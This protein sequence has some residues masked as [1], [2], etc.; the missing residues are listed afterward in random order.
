MVYMAPVFGLFG[1][2]MALVEYVNE[3]CASDRMG[4]KGMELFTTG[5]CLF[6]TNYGLVNGHNWRK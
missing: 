4:I 1:V 2:S 5:Q 6:I 3:D